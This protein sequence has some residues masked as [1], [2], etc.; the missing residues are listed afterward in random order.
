NFCTLELRIRG[1]ALCA[2]CERSDGVAVTNS[3]RYSHKLV[4]VR[5]NWQTRRTQN[6]VAARPCG[7]DSLHQHQ[8]SR[9][10]R[11]RN[12]A[13]RIRASRETLRPS[14]RRDESA[15]EGCQSKALY[16]EEQIGSREGQLCSIPR[17]CRLGLAYIRARFAFV[18]AL[19]G[20]AWER[21]AFGDDPAV[22]GFRERDVKNYS[23]MVGPKSR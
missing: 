21:R 20:T 16:A 7:F 12:K 6:P 9:P 17:G 5:R 18:L 11:R 1:G 22:F 19:R 4:L 2:D 10:H 14:S 3:V 15:R 13:S 8:H 23:C